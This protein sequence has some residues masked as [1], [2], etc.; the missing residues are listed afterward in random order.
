MALSDLALEEM[1]MPKNM[2]MSNQ[3]ENTMGQNL[4]LPS[5]FERQPE[6][7]LPM[8]PEMSSQDRE[9][10]MFNGLGAMQEKD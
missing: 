9:T 2:R 8:T 10:Q 6:R 7:P 3:E 5:T 1:T 4:L